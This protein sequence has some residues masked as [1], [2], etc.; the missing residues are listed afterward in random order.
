M[1]GASIAALGIHA[2]DG[3]EVLGKID[4]DSDNSHGLPLPNEFMRPPLSIVALVVG[5]RNTRPVRDGEI[6]FIP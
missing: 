3:I 4:S 1:R 2:V 5:R 6:P